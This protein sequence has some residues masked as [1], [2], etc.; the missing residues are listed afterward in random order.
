[1]IATVLGC[2]QS[3]EGWIPRGT[4]IGSNDCEKFGKPV[5]ILILANH[6]RKFGDR[7]KTI[8]K[9][10]AKVMVTSRQQWQNI[11][12]NCEKITRITSFNKM[13]VK[14]YVYTSTTTPIMCLS[15]AIRMGAT[16]IVM[17]GVDMISHKTYRTGTKQGDRE[18][19][20]YLRFFEACNKKGIEIYRGA[21]GSIFD[22][23]LPLYE[24]M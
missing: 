17:Y 6:P 20:T 1:M 8:K 3:A 21:D 23:V 16:K 14:G 10:Q 7:L 15:L 22:K 4:V 13:L 24:N 9:T 2:G 19:A 11:F 12:P 18:I 5:D